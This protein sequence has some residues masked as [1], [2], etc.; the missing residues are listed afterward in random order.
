MMKI[1]VAF[2]TDVREI[3][4]GMGTGNC[5]T[6]IVNDAINDST[7]PVHGFIISCNDNTHLMMSIVGEF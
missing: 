7:C 1:G 2:T 6:F 4:H 5:G 3:D